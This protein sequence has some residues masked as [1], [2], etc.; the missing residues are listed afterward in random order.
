MFVAGAFSTIPGA[1]V[2]YLGPN[3]GVRLGGGVMATCFIVQFLVCTRQIDVGN[4]NVLVVM[5]ILAAIQFMSSCSITASVFPTLS[6]MYQP[7]ES[8]GLVIG[9]G[10]GWVG[11]FGNNMTQYM[12]TYI[13]ICG[14]SKA[15]HH[16]I[17]I[18]VHVLIPLTCTLSIK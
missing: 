7:N 1:L 5:C 18:F 16:Y 2:D 12:Y 17:Y 13:Y 3:K 8:R 6:A 14:Y 9:E 15:Y 10:K 11:L 4:D